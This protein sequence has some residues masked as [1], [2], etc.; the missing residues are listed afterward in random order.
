MA[1]RGALAAREGVVAA[2][3]EDRR[4]LLGGARRE[5]HRGRR[6]LGF[7][8]RLGGCGLGSSMGVALAELHVR[9]RLRLAAPTRALC[10]GRRVGACPLLLRHAL[11]RLPRDG[12][13]C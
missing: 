5:R 2:L 11:L 8:G 9:L 13:S 12:A 1:A 4:A 7:G 10:G 3:A 6:G